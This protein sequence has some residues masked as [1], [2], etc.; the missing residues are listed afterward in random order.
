[1]EVEGTPMYTW[2]EIR[3]TEK[4]GKPN[5]YRPWSPIGNRSL[6]LHPVAAD[7]KAKPGAAPTMVFSM[8]GDGYV[9]H[10]G[11]DLTALV[12]KVP[13]LCKLTAA[14]GVDPMVLVLLA[15]EWTLWSHEGRGY[16]GG[17]GA[18]TGLGAVGM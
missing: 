17:G 18:V 4:S 10:S 11:S 12:G 1:M 5:S 7:G 9:M 15:V 3:V 13:N 6:T 14:A 8:K 2:F 16:G